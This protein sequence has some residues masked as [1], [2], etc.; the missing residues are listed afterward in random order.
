MIEHES[1]EPELAYRTIHVVY[2]DE[3]G[4][5][6]SYEEHPSVVLATRE[7]N[8]EFESMSDTLDR[9]REALQ[10]PVLKASEFSQVG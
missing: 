9:M 4:R 5:A 6:H 7:D 1:S 10:K 8:G 3:T 2:Y